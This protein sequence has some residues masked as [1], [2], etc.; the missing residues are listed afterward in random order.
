EEAGRIPNMRLLLACRAFDLQH[1][2]RLRALTGEGRLAATIELSPLDVEQVRTVVRAAGGDPQRLDGRQIELLRI[3][4]NLQLFLQGDPSAQAS[5]HSVKEL[6]DR[7]WER[8][9][10]LVAQKL[11]HARAWDECISTL[12]TELSNGSSCVPVDVLDRHGEDAMTM[13]SHGVLVLEN[14]RWRFFH[15]TFGDY[16]FARQFVRERRDLVKF[17]T[18]DGG[19]QHLYRRAQV[20]QILAYE[21]DRDRNAYLGKLRS[22][23][24][25]PTVRLHIKKLTLEWLSQ[26]PDPGGDEWK[27]VEGLMGDKVLGAHALAVLWGSV[28]WFD[29]LH[30]LDIWPKLLA[31]EQNGLG[32]RCARTLTMGGMME[33]R[34]AVLAGLFAPYLQDLPKWRNRFA[35]LFHHGNVHHSRE[36]FDLALASLEGGFFDHLHPSDLL[37][38]HLVVNRPGY[39]AEFIGRF[40]DRLCV[41][42]QQAGETNPFLSGAS[43]RGIRDSEIRSVADQVPLIFAQQLAP[44]LEKL[45]L[46]NALPA[47]HGL[48]RDKIWRWLTFGAEHD[49]D[50]ALLFS[51]ARALHK[52]A[53]D[54][55]TLIASLTRDWPQMP[56]RTIRFLLFRAWSGNGAAFADQAAEYLITQPEAL[57]FG[58]GAMVAAEGDWRAAIS[59]E[60]VEVIGPHCPNDLHGR[61]ESAIRALHVTG[62]DA[63]GRSQRVIEFALMR[64]LRPE[65]LSTESAARLE[66]LEREFPQAD[67]APPRST[68]FRFV[69][70]ALPGVDFSGLSDEE[71]LGLFRQYDQEDREWQRDGWRVEVLDI[72]GPLRTRASLERKRFA[73]LAMRMSDEV[74]PVYF[75]TILEAVGTKPD[76]GQNTPQQALLA[77]E[78]VYKVI[79]RLHS[80]PNRPCGRAINWVLYRMADH[81]IPAQMADIVGYYVL[82]DPDPLPDNDERAGKELVNHAINTSQGSAV[83]T[84]ARML[85]TQPDLAAGFL[86]VL[87][88]LAHAPSRSIRAVTIHALVALLNRDRVSA[89]RLFGEICDPDPRIWASHHV[90]DFIHYATQTHHTALRPL[91]QRIIA[92]NDEDAKSVAARQICLAAFSHQEA[93]ADLPLVLDGD[94]VCRMAAAQIY[95]DNHLHPSIR[96]ACERHLLPLLNDKEQEVRRVAGYWVTNL[97]LVAAAGDWTFFRQY[98]ETEAFVE[99]P[100]MCLHEL[101][102]IATVPSEVILRLAD[103]A[104][105]LSQRD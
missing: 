94:K 92:S 70:S 51:T 78:T 88:Q 68:G 85:F 42:A 1:D 41:L 59:R 31:D 97:K 9:A 89:V 52:T 58:Y 40:L 54:S 10:A 93:Q 20:R 105:E 39:A 47:D 48:V 45:I 67:F 60:L 83:D 27:V 56:H 62:E 104:I 26:L 99:E 74:M 61:L 16:A 49:M 55:P 22:L 8:K 81:P 11:S 15:E 2:Q 95:A 98:M 13:A 17:L 24:A 75:S 30:R 46:A 23:L 37:M 66:E 7:F 71:W 25:E 35:T 4:F 80:L 64:C 21:R 38:H 34:S 96:A 82:K 57:A 32:D 63:N 79:E 76:T 5:F 28:P 90:E 103:R 87:E 3:P 86:P 43:R 73:A 53:L 44:R 91:L 100:G 72:T 33:K 50:D 65:R 102:D 69:E 101:E 77:P 29:L 36:M 6:F 18:V 84:I 14:R 19:E 12:A